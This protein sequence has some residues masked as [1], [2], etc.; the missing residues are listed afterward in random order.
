M[1]AFSLIVVINLL[2]RFT[3][4]IQGGG[5]KRAAEEAASRLQDILAKKAVGISQPAP[6]Q[7]QNHVPRA[8]KKRSRWS[9]EDDLKTVIPGLSTIMPAGLSKEQQE[10]Y[11]GNNSEVRPEVIFKY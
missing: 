10:A 1:G 11:L 9:N 4:N 2:N 3:M 5:N 6:V 8:K 7:P